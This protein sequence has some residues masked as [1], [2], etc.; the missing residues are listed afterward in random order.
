MNCKDHPEGGEGRLEKLSDEGIVEVL[1]G[2]LN[3]Q[4]LRHSA[5]GS[6]SM[7]APD[8]TEL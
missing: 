7:V 2:K 4:H 6:S 1:T 5:S 8:K 3:A